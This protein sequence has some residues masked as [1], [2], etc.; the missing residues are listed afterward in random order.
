[1]NWRDKTL[2]GRRGYHHGNLREALIAAA[3][4][5]ISEKGAAGFTF[6]DVARAAG[7]SP[8]APYRHFRDQDAL[9]A[10]V[11][12]Q[13]FDAFEK[14]LAAAWNGGKPDPV[15]ALDAV[16]QAYLAFARTEPAFYAAMFEGGAPSGTAPELKSAGDRAFA[17]LHDAVAA[18]VATLPSAERPPVM[19]MSLHV[20]AMTHGIASLFGRGDAGRRVIPMSPT[21]LLE[22]AMLIYLRGVRGL[23]RN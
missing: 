18:V 16:G 22:A 10:A 14:A 21:E 13:G 9:M 12:A 7:V 19:M 5:L 1:M 17:V 4:S 2:G 20:W 6:A 23:G 8:A 3:L 11:A 15:A